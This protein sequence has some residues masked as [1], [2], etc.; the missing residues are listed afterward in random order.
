MLEN[1]STVKIQEGINQVKEEIL[2][3]FPNCS[4][5]I[6]IT[7]W[8]DGT[9]QTEC[10]HGEDDGKIYVA[11]FY[12]NGLTVDVYDVYYNLRQLADTISQFDEQTTTSI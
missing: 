5:T 3:R 8:D 6:G 1:Q 7:L 12:D 4:Y 10:R 2:R 9:F 11:R